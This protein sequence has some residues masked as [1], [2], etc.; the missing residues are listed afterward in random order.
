MTREGTPQISMSNLVPIK[1]SIP[2]SRTAILPDKPVALN[3][4]VRA[5]AVPTPMAPVVVPDLPIAR[6][7]NATLPPE[8]LTSRKVIKK[9]SSIQT[10]TVAAGQTFAMAAY[11]N[12]WQLLAAPAPISIRYDPTAGFSTYAPGLGIMID[13]EAEFGQLEIQNTYSLPI[14]VT[15]FFGWDDQSA[16]VAPALPA[17][18]VEGLILVTAALQT[19]GTTNA[20][21][22]L[23]FN[24]SNG[25]TAYSAPLGH[26]YFRTG[27][28]YGYS[29][30]NGSTGLGPLTPNANNVYIGKTRFAFDTIVPGNWV[31]YDAPPGEFLDLGLISF[32]GSAGTDGLYFDLTI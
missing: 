11:G 19:F 31:R 1:P 14:T 3:D 9:R 21:A 15:L 26:F 7:V 29:F 13:V 27:F 24:G 22:S 10:V 23:W 12:R 16:F 4:L 30:L 17:T 8:V 32:N 20:V 25:T 5:P 28:F 2:L 18:V 6:T